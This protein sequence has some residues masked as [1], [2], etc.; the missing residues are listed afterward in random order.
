MSLGSILF[1]LNYTIALPV[2]REAEVD[3]MPALLIS[4]CSIRLTQDEQLIPDT[5]NSIFPSLMFTESARD[6]LKPRLKK[7][8]CESLQVLQG[9]ELILVFHVNIA[10]NR[11]QTSHQLSTVC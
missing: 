7:V 11:H 5:I 8:S 4:V 1:E 3:L 10:A 9:V 6:V 2:A